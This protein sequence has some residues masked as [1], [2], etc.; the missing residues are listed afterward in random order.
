M[1]GFF[2]NLLTSFLKCGILSIRKASGYPP[3]LLKAERLEERSFYD[4]PDSADCYHNLNYLGQELIELF[5]RF[6]KLLYFFVQFHHPLSVLFLKKMIQ[7][8]HFYEE[9]TQDR[10]ILLRITK[11]TTVFL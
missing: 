5:E 11:N 10:S 8:R 6:G 7:K 3:S 9:M 4:R 2:I 1:F